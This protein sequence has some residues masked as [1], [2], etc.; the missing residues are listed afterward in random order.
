MRRLLAGL[1]AAVFLTGCATLPP[2]KRDVRD[3]L[4]RTNRAVFTFNRAADRAVLRPAAKVWQAVVPRPVRTGLGNFSNN[5]GYPTTI[6]NEY[7]QGKGRDGTA[8]IARL[9]VNTVFGLGFF[10]PASHIGLPRHNEDFG[11]T[12]G[13]WGVHPGAYLM[14]P[15]LGPSTV[16]DA[17]ARIVDAYSSGGQYLNDQYLRWSLAAA[18]VL[19]IRAELLATDGML[20]SS[21]DPYALTRNAWLKRREYEVRDG[22]VEWDDASAPDSS[23][24][25]DSPALEEPPDAPADMPPDPPT[26]TPAQAAGRAPAPDPVTP[27]SNPAR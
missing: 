20:E 26:A 17:P 18:N 21:F 10:D 6:L 1:A 7:L 23:V 9:V 8:D 14:V 25:D 2:G 15:I 4:E 12:L 22:N 27:A 13:K 24:S 3:P 19:E 11:Q 16:R 5:L